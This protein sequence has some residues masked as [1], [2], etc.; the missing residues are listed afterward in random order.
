MAG[1]CTEEFLVRSYFHSLA[2][3]LSIVFIIDVGLQFKGNTRIASSIMCYSYLM[4]MLRV[5]LAPCT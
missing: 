3:R 4:A 2:H 5:E 1:D